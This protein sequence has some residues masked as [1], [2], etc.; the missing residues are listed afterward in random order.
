M[1]TAEPVGFI[2][3]VTVCLV[4]VQQFEMTKSTRSPG[5]TVVNGVPVLALLNQFPGSSVRFMVS[6]APARA[7]TAAA[8]NATSRSDINLLLTKYFVFMRAD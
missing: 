8:V 3:S 5:L 1:T 4:L 6:T 2:K 7:E